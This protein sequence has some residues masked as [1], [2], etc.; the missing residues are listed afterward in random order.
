L[1]NL[2]EPT[3]QKYDVLLKRLF[4]TIK[5][6]QKIILEGFESSNFSNF[7]DVEQLKD[8]QDKFVLFCKRILV[9][10]DDKNLVYQYELLTFLMHIQHTYYYMYKYAYENKIKP[11][12]KA[13]ELQKDLIG[14][15][16]LFFNAYFNKDMSAVNKIQKQKD[17]F[18]FGKCFKYLESSKGKN[19]IIFSYERELFRLI[20]IST[21]PVIASIID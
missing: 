13:I 8:Q 7:K 6:T 4:F 14:Y 1:E 5:E 15:F 3:D 16:E 12:Q 9:S 10:K 21:S 17:E 19:S 2:A 11:D 20:Q 18:Q